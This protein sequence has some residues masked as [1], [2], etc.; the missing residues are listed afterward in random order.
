MTYPLGYPL[1]SSRT[2]PDRGNGAGSGPVRPTKDLRSSTR[3]STRQLTVIRG[4]L[5]ARDREVL[6]LVA[7]FRVMSGDQLQRLFWPDGSPQ[8]RARL[9]RH[10]LS[11]LSELDVLAPLARRVGGVRAGSAGTCFAA[12]LAGQRLLSSRESAR[13]VRRLYTPGERYLTHTLA[14]GQLYVELVETGRRKQAELVVYQPEPEC[15]RAF[16]GPFGARIPCKPD[17]Y[18]KLGVGDYDYSW[19]VELDM[20]SESLTTIERKATC[21]L[22]Y[23]RSGAWQRTHGVAARVAWI[24]P[25]A[26]RATQVQTALD[27]LPAE[28]GKLFAVA[29]AADAVTLLTAQARS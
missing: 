3:L 12:G 10:G 4:R 28:A 6:E 2:A 13:R 11:R 25:D 14:V 27:R 24:V 19:L 20:A 1:A 23:Y 15:W 8:T 16:L 5:S 21:H 29:T 26:R 17:A 18:V 9:A 7:R 22:G